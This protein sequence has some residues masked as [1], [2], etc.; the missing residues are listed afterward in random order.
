MMMVLMI[1]IIIIVRMIK[2]NNSNYNEYNDDSNDD[3]WDNYRN[4]NCSISSNVVRV[5]ISPKIIGMITLEI[6][7]DNDQ[8]KK[9]I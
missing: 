4:S 8:Y 5:A 3:K 2:K 9:I 1:N 7:H 6:I